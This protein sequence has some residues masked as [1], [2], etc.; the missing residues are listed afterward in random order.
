MHNANFM[1]LMLDSPRAH[2][3]ALRHTMLRRIQR[4]FAKQQ[5]TWV[6]SVILYFHTTL[7]K[8]ERP[9]FK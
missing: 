8:V 5:V 6:S 4:V 3:A 9:D 7:A 2:G 1:L